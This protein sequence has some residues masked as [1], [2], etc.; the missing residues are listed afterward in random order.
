MCNCNI[1]GINATMV[2]SCLASLRPTDVVVYGSLGAAVIHQITEQQSTPHTIEASARL[3][4]A[5]VRKAARFWFPRGKLQPTLIW[6]E[7]EALYIGQAADSFTASPTWVPDQEG[8]CYQSATIDRV[9]RWNAAA[10]TALQALSHPHVSILRIWQSMQVSRDPVHTQCPLLC[11]RSFLGNWADRLLSM[12]QQDLFGVR[13]AESEDLR[14]ARST[15]VGPVEFTPIDS[16]SSTFSLNVQGLATNLGAAIKQGC[17]PCAELTTRRWLVA[18]ENSM[19]SSAFRGWR[20]IKYQLEA[21]TNPT[22][23]QPGTM[24]AMSRASQLWSFSWTDCEKLDRLM[25]AHSIRAVRCQIVPLYLAFPPEYFFPYRACRQP[26]QYDALLFG[27]LNTRRAALCEELLAVVPP[28]RVKCSSRLYGQQL[29]RAIARSQLVFGLEFYQDDSLPVHRINQV[30]AEQ[31]PMVHPP[32]SDPRLDSLYASWGVLFTPQMN[33]ARRIIQLV[34]NGTAEL[35]DARARTVEFAKHVH[36]ERRNASSGLCAALK[37]A[38]N[39][40]A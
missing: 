39:D 35:E 26:I 19:A 31:T 30:L 6:R 20:L 2:Q 40:T 32:S 34:H 38:C 23:F 18:F 29:R 4:V 13:P 11:E 10:N 36:Q 24:Q 21:F 33:L 1:I 16:Q 17:M 9:K 12:F 22:K 28:L 25:H 3:E 27:T 14:K 37:Q 5:T 8:G 15:K 7:A